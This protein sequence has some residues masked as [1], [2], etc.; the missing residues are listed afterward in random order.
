MLKPRRSI[1]FA[2]LLAL[3]LSVSVVAGPRHSHGDPDIVEGLKSKDGISQV[4]LLSAPQAV[5]V[6]DLPF[7]GRILI[8][9]QAQRDSQ[10]IMSK[11]LSAASTRTRK[12]H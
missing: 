3:L 6:I 12:H 4:Q 5:Y 9:R 11:R 10:D 2:L 7:L 1:P 8:V